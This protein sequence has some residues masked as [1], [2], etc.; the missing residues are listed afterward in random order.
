MKTKIAV[1]TRF[2]SLAPCNEFRVTL[3]LDQGIQESFVIDQTT[4]NKLDI[5]RIDFYDNKSYFE[6]FFLL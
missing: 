3:R 6:S 1:K 2:R 4:G 5:L